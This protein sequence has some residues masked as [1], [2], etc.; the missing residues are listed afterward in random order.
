MPNR[1]EYLSH[2]VWG[3]GRKLHRLCTKSRNAQELPCHFYSLFVDADGT[4][5]PCCNSTSK[6]I[7]HISETNSLELVRYRPT[8]CHCSSSPLGHLGYTGPIAIRPAWKEDVPRVSILHV[9]STLNCQA[10]CA[11]CV[12]AL[13]RD[14]RSGDQS[15]AEH[16][17][18]LVDEIHPSLER[19]FIQGGEIGIDRKSIS[20]LRQIKEKYPHV[21]TRVISNACLGEAD[22]EWFTACVDEAYFSFVGFSEAS[23]WVSS[24]LNLKRTV[25]FVE[26]VVGSGTVK[27]VLKYLITPINIHEIHEFLEWCYRIAPDGDVLISAVTS[28]DKYVTTFSPISA[29]PERGFRNRFLRWLSSPPKQVTR[30]LASSQGHDL[31][32]Y[33][34]TIISRSSG[35]I[36]EVVRQHQSSCGTRVVFDERAQKLLGL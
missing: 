21:T 4:T 25:D 1:R 16:V 10:R 27:V 23:Y 5:S 22:V 12:Q 9:V 14:T 36:Q 2:L 7:G 28:F 26:K 8:S 32:D 29:S 18:K 6:S 30:V 11:H 35:A 20:L 15:L 31:Y 17:L 34:K 13:E 3:L 24:K 19:V 33:W